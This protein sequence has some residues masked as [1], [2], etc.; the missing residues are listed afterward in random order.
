MH[1]SHGC[2]VPGAECLVLCLV[3]SA[4]C[5][6]LRRKIPLL[7]KRTVSRLPPSKCS[8]NGLDTRCRPNEKFPRQPVGS[9]AAAGK[10]AARAQPCAAV[11]AVRRTTTR[12]SRGVVQKA[13]V[14]VRKQVLVALMVVGILAL[15]GS[16]PAY[17]QGSKVT[18]PFPF[19]VG[20]TVLPAGSYLVTTVA[21]RSDV[22]AIRSVDG[23]A[24][25]T[26]LMQATATW[27]EKRHIVLSFQRYG[28]RF[29]LSEVNM[30]GSNGRALPLPKQQLEAMLARLNGKPVPV[31]H[32]M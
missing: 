13:K 29:F 4:S 3:P 23:K 21:E 18:V 25:A 27:S 32:T 28:G 31:G 14:S 16:V 10:R 9:R 22:L 30:P 2:L 26:A 1:E 7:G 24:M 11:W 19:I 15:A 12:T 8:G 6:A 20:E 5:C 17:A